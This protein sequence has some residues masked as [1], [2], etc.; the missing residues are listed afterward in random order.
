MRIFKIV[1]FVFLLALSFKGNAQLLGCATPTLTL[2]DGSPPFTVLSPSIPCT[3]TNWVRVS[4]SPNSYGYTGGTVTSAAAPCLRFQTS[5]TNANSTTNNFMTIYQGTNNIGSVCGTTCALSVP[6][7]S[8]YTLYYASLTPTLSHSYVLC[9]TNVAANFTYSVMSCFNNVVLASGTWTNT[10][11]GGCQTVTI[12]A[13]TSIGTSSFAISPTITPSAY[14]D[15]GQGSI[16]IDTYQI[17]AG[18]YTMTYFFDSQSGCTSTQT[19]TFTITNPY[20]ATWTTPT[21]QCSTFPCITLTTNITGT[22]GGVFLGT[23][24][25]SNSFC[26]GTSGS[27]S[28]P[29]TY[30]VGI[31]PTCGASLTNTIT[32]NTTPTA[33]AGS[34]KTLNCIQTTTIIN[35]SGG[36]T[37]TWTGPGA[38]SSNLQN[39]TVGAPGTYTLSVTTASCISSPVTVAVNQNT[40]QPASTAAT[41]GSITCTT[42]TISLTAGPGSMN[43]TWTAPGGSSISSGVNSSSA[44]GQGPGTYTV[45]VLDPNNGCSRTATV[46]AN[47]NTV[48]PVPTA[49]TTGSITCTTNTVSL[50]TNLTGMNYTWT[51]PGGSSISSGVN[52]QN[53]V[54]QGSG[55]YTVNVQDPTNGCSRTATVAANINTVAPTATATTSGSITCSSNT[56]SLGALPAGMNYTWTA[57]GGSSITGGV[58][59][60][61]TTGQGAGTYT[62]RVQSLVNGCATNTTIAAVINTVA[63]TGLLPST[64]GTVTCASGAINL[65]VLPGSMTYSWTAPVGASITSGT[66]LQSANATGPGTY[67]VTVTNPVNGCSSATTIAANTNT[68]APTPSISPTP[69]ITCTNTVVTLT[70]NPSSGVLYAWSGPGIVSASNQAT[71]SV[72]QIGS[73]SLV[74]TSTA[75][76]CTATVNATVANNLIPPTITPVATQTITCAAPTVTLIGSANPSSC[77]VVWTGGVCGGANSFT[78]TACAP[79]TYTYI[80][81]NPANGCPSAA[82]VATVVPNNIPS[83]TI[84]NTGTITCSNTTVQVVATTTTTPATL[85]W[86]GPGIVSGAGTATI[87][88]NAGGTYSLV[89]LN[90]S[91]SCSVMVTNSVTADNA[92]ITPTTTSSSTI[93]CNTTT[94]NLTTNVGAGAYTYNWSGPA[95]VGTTTLSTATASLGGLYTVTVTNTSNGC[96]GTGTVSVVS[97]TT[98]PTGLAIN[99][100]TFTLSCATPTTVLTATATGATSYTWIAPSGGSIISGTNTASAG[101]SGSGTYSVIVAGTNGCPSA[102]AEATISPNNNAPTFTI[103]NAFPS[104]TCFSTSPTVSVAITSTVPILSYVWTPTLGISGVT[105]TSVVTFTAAG[106]YT[107][108]VTANNGCTSNAIISVTSATDAP[109]VVAGTATAQVI[110]CTNSV[111]SISPTFTPSTGLTYTWT[112][113]GVV[114]TA[115]DAS[116]TVNQ[117]GTYSL[118]ITNTLTGCTSNSITVAV[119]GTSVPPLLNITSSSSVGIACLPGTSTIVLTANATPSTGVTY[120]WSTSAITESISVTSAGVYSVIVTDISTSCSVAVQYTVDNNSATPNL[121]VTA[122]A[123]MPCGST[124]TLTLNASSTSTNVSYAWAGP[125]IISGS[126][127][128]TPVIDQP[129]TYTVM[130][131]DA[132]TGCMN[133]ATVSVVNGVPTASFTADVNSGYAPLTVN[134]T[135]LSSGAISYNWDFGNGGS[136]AVNPSNVYSTPGTYSVILIATSGICSDT[137]SMVIIVDNGFSIEI[138]NVFTPN[139]D[140]V[141]DLFTIKST[142]VKELTL[143]IFNRW[144]QKMYEFSG[145]KAAWDGVTGNGNDAPSGTYFYLIKAKGVDDTLYE[146]QGPVSLFR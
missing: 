56:I 17:P 46:A 49:S 52:S 78:A 102:A 27:G 50:T 122:N 38:F 60:Q 72:N 8:L 51:A 146:K 109:T 62:V 23:G 79:G 129:G 12:P 59:S 83:A 117:S 55:T 142:G 99:P 63:P 3:Y 19:K 137:A 104:I 90:T 77:T 14:V 4:T 69:T 7:N 141:N 87:V 41:S 42:N 135:N 114:G 143:E 75:N 20:V 112:G 133:T 68:T 86:S 10:V 130:I 74:V 2:A 48:Q 64:S 138:P 89:L 43:Y 136:T 36:T 94:V 18:T 70:G 93:T 98:A 39:P 96:V 107:G 101:I 91:T 16:Y 123:V 124:T 85:T 120:N 132:I 131:M 6:S 32:V 34:T 13:N 118:A 145:T 76:S 53:A 1:I 9:N 45:N 127:A 97:N 121:S 24:V 73:Y 26:P 128:A 30:T 44:V 115:N 57:P 119:V 84:V 110:S 105:N 82:Q 111:V 126:N 61:N 81:T 58:N 65:S 15:F 88:V 5:L 103:S 47:I 71:V 66:T 116:V 95:V 11:A 28:F 144:G 22:S 139:N 125:S 40:T 54:G 21:V 134:F 113:P 80:A 29:V 106:T 37:Y 35:G 100:P 92:A 67:T 25:S 108:V 31:T 33:N 140:G